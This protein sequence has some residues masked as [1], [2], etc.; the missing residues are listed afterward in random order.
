MNSLLVLLKER[1]TASIR[2]CF[3]TSKK[4]MFLRV[5]KSLVTIN[6]IV[7]FVYQKS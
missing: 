3:E 1:L 2:S 7:L 4:Q 6:A 5:A